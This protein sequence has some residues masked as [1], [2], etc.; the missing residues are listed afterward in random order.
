MRPDANVPLPAP[1]ASGRPL[2]ADELMA[3]APRTIELVDGRIPGDEELVLLLLTSLGLRRV[4]ALVGF[5]LWRSALPEHQAWT[6]DTVWDRP[7]ETSRDALE[8]RL[9]AELRLRKEGLAELLAAA[10]NH[11]GYEDPVYRFYHQSFKVYRLQ[12]TT[13][14]IVRELS[15]LLP[16]QPLNL[17]FLEML[18]QGTG[19]TFHLDDNARWTAVTRPMVEAFF[20]ARYFLEMAVRYASLEAPPRPLPSGYAA[21]L[22]L[23]GLR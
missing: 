17:W 20:H 13:K 5:D 11:W 23:Y 2:T 12:E 18:G 22:Y 3:F 7:D 15:A 10:S 8:L 21:L 16:G 6:T 19:R 14:Q 4:A 1:D 9:L